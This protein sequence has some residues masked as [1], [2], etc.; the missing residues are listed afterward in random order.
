MCKKFIKDYPDLTIEATTVQAVQLAR[1]GKAKEAVTL[2]DKQAKGEHYLPTK[3]ACVQLLLSNEERAEAIKILENLTETEKSLPGIVSTLVT[4]HMA[5]NDRDRASA[6]LKN[7]V[8]YYKKNKVFLKFLLYY[9]LYKKK[10]K[11]IFINLFRNSG[12]HRKS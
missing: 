2:L 12:K 11:Q 9:I 3:L 7:A 8:N 1:E 4:L 6:V 10:S 5:N